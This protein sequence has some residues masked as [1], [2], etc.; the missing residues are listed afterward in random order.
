[1]NESPGP[2]NFNRPG[3]SRRRALTWLGT[4]GVAAAT[5]LHFP[6][7]HAQGPATTIKVGYVPAASAAPLLSPVA[8]G[9]FKKHG[10][11][12][13]TVQVNSGAAAVPLLLN[14]Q[15]DATTSDPVAVVLAV[16]Q[17]VPVGIAAGEVVCPQDPNQD[18]TGVLVRKD[19]KIL[20]AKDLNGTTLGIFGLKG[21]AHLL[22]L[23][24]IDK[25][26]GDSS[27][28]NFATVP[29][30]QAIQ[31]LENSRVDAVFVVEPFMTTAV[32]SGSVRI[33]I[34]PFSAALPGNPQALYMGSRKFA[35]EKPAAYRSF[36]A[37][38]NELNLI[39]HKDREQVVAGLRKLKNVP[40]A[41]IEKIRLPQFPATEQESL[42]GL[43]GVI[44]LMNKYKFIQKPVA[45][46]QVILA[47]R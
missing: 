26:G 9:V 38:V 45:L 20:S 22:T 7:V 10:L 47:A 35:D 37:A 19:S 17:G 31:T 12:L 29:L 4:A 18:Y 28:V 11:V 42:A 43:Q 13:E 6:W 36:V 30:P 15:L 39:M 40:E 44:D 3:G 34:N 27:S 2:M 23:A 16:S 33:L 5:A 41:L 46:D 1:M 8:A 32:G 24:A 14:G 21:L 25:L